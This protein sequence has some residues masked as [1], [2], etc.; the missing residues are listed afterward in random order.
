[1]TKK[2]TV[3][4]KKILGEKK[5]IYDSIAREEFAKQKLIAKR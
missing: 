4:A 2:F 3:V 1:M 5:E